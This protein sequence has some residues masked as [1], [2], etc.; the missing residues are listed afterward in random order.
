[1]PMLPDT[2][3]PGRDIACK[4]V[5]QFFPDA[6]EEGVVF[7]FWEFLERLEKEGKIR[8]ISAGPEP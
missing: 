5:R 1:M 7:D 3:G 2:C 6:V 4:I 8:L